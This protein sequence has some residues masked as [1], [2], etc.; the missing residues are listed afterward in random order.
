LLTYGDARACAIADERGTAAYMHYAARPAAAT[1][2]N[3]IRPMFIGLRAD[4]GPDQIRALFAH[5]AHTSFND[6]TSTIFRVALEPEDS[7]LSGHL[8]SLGLRLA[9]RALDMRLT[10]PADLG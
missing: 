7:S 10:M 8:D 6:P 5:A 9:G 2:P 1:D 4:A 3:R